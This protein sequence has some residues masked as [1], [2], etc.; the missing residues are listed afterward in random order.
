M[1]QQVCGFY[2]FG[3]NI[4]ASTAASI[5]LW[6]DALLLD[7]PMT[8]WSFINQQVEEEKEETTQQ[9]LHFHYKICWRPSLGNVSTILVVQPT[10]PLLYTGTQIAVPSSAKRKII[11]RKFTNDNTSPLEINDKF[12][13]KLKCIENQAQTNLNHFFTLHRNYIIRPRVVAHGSQTPPKG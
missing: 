4:C 12:T 7:S 5:N 6:Q 3:H 9:Q 8:E 10:T 1:Q 2:Y 11:N 13:R